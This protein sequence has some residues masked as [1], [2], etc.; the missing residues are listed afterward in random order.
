MGNF[1]EIWK[2]DFSGS[3][4]SLPDESKW[5]I[6]VSGPNHGNNEVQHYTKHHDN[7]SV[8]DGQ[9]E[10]TPRHHDGKW[11]SARLEGKGA[12]HC[13]EGETFKVEATLKIGTAPVDHQS[14][15]WP[16]FWTLGDNLRTNNVPW[17]QCGEIDIYEGAHGHAYSLATVHYGD[18]D[19]G[20]G[21]NADAKKEFNT[22]EFHTWAVI[23][24][25][26]ASRWQDETITWYCDGKQFFKITGDDVAEQGQWASLAHKDIFP[27]LNVAIGSTFPGSGQPNDLTATGLGSGLQVKHVGFYKTV[28]PP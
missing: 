21:G 9:L 23:I 26:V 15:V 24:D 25:R 18:G 10:I 5:N 14:G 27:V 16:A 7:V 11:T 3:N 8:R 17:P 13:P 4:G 2:D 12:F 6:I 28:A 19:L 22:G 1:E 20:G